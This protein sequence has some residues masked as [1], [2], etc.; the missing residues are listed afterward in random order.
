MQ[1]LT[2]PRCA[3]G[4]AVRHRFDADRRAVLRLR[5]IEDIWDSI[6]HDADAISVAEADI[7]EAERRLAEHRRDPRRWPTGA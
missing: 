3:L 5:L 1:G 6:A 7:R 2:G 4:G